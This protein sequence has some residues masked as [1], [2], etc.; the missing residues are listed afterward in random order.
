M[1]LSHRITVAL[2]CISEHVDWFSFFLLF[3]FSNARIVTSWDR[4]GYCSTMSSSQCYKCSGLGHFARECS[5]NDRSGGGGYNYG[6]GREKCYKCNRFGH[7]AR[8]CKVDQDRCY[9]CHGAGHIAKHCDRSPNEPNCYNCHKS[10]HF[11][12]ECPESNS[13]GG[14]SANCY[15]CKKPGHMARDCPDGKSSYYRKSGNSS[16]NFDVDD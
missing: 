7:F 5:Q 15:N 9:N 4:L 11:A 1:S 14:F 16:R 3:K 2:R 12:R 6:R 8:E 13:R 10:G